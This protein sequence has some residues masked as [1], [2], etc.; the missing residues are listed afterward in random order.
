MILSPRP[1]TWNSFLELREK[2]RVL[3]GFLSEEERGQ[4]FGG[5]DPSE[6]GSGMGFVLDTNTVNCFLKADEAIIQRVINA[7]KSM[8][9]NKI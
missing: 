2:S 9:Y 7:A 5:R 3:E 8:Y 4:D 6:D 1:R